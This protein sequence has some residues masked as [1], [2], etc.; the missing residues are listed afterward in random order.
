MLAFV[1]A[2]SAGVLVTGLLTLAAAVRL[3][4]EVE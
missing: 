3:A 4:R 2:T 1:L